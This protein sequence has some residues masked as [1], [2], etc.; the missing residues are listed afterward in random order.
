[1]PRIIVS[2]DLLTSDDLTEVIAQE[3]REYLTQYVDVLARDPRVEI[4]P[5]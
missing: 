4:R 5:D 1:M 3:L 2:L